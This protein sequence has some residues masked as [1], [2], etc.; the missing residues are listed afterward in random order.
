MNAR[1]DLRLDD[2][3]HCACVTVLAGYTRETAVAALER[4]ELACGNCGDDG[5]GSQACVVL[6][7]GDEAVWRGGC[8]AKAV[9]A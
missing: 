6:Y 2:C 8:A 1:P 5:D 7:D 4:G 3:A 9:R